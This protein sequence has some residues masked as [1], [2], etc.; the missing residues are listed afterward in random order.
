MKK[1]DILTAALVG[2]FPAAFRIALKLVLDWECELNHVT[3]EIEWENDPDDSGAAT[4]AG[5]LLKEGEVAT[6]P[7]PHGIVHVYFDKYWKPLAGLPVLVQEVVF[8]E[9]VNIGIETAIECL[10]FAL[11]DYGC[12]LV[13]DGKLGD[14]TRQASF[15]QGDVTGLCMAFLQKCRRHYEGIASD[16][17]SQGK[18][19]QGWLNRLDATK[20][21]LA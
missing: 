3:G 12:R 13:V 2:G 15:A 9:G 11:N 6:S 1:S 21:L 7:D 18:F 16:H 14:Q 19:L 17:P 4:F 8:V 10:Q 20:G 5:L